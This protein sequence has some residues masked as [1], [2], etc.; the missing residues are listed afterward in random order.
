[1]S[2]T[3]TYDEPSGSAEARLERIGQLEDG[4]AVK[5]ADQPF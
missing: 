1:M 3:Q 5:A 4:E 2:D